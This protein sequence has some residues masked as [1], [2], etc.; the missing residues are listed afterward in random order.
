MIK[1]D[2]MAGGSGTLFWSLFRSA[3]PTP[4]MLKSFEPYIKKV[5]KD[6]T[7]QYWSPY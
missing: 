4:P 3:R 7:C 1:A 2:V 6:L 5:E